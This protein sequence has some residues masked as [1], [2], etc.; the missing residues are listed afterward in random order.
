[1]P[2]GQNMIPL[3]NHS[4][5]NSADHFQLKC[6]THLE[7]LINFVYPDMSEDVRL[8]DD[9]AILA[10]TNATIDKCNDSLARHRSGTSVSFFSSDSSFGR[11]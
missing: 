9:R 8:W 10:T 1:M 5:L 11:V 3:N 2:D 6:T 7:D 4:R